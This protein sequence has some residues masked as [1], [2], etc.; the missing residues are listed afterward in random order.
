MVHYAGN[1]Q[2]DGFQQPLSSSRECCEDS[3]G[4]K[5]SRVARDLED[6]EH[7]RLEQTQLQTLTP[8]R[9]DCFGALNEARNKVG[10]P[11]TLQKTETGYPLLT[12]PS[13]ESPTGWSA[14]G[15][16]V[17]G[18]E[19]ETEAQK[20]KKFLDSLCAAILKVG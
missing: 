2:Y 8:S 7:H 1:L 18:G 17:S 3:S 4:L 20:D 13:E 12:P 16:T 5:R 15:E 19:S 6:G 10:L 14:A 11:A 9:V